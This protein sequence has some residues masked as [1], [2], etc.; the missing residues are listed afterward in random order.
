MDNGWYSRLFLVIGF[1]ALAGYFLYPS[2]YYFYEATDE[3][4]DSH[5]K[6]CEAMPGG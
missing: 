2:Y 4:R 3:Q 5:E 6:F 1:V